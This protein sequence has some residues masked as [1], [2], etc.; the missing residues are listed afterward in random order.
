MGEPTLK[1]A[2][3][4]CGG[5]G[6]ADFKGMEAVC[7]ECCGEGFVYAQSGTTRRQM[8]IAHLNSVFVW[9]NNDTL[10]PRK[11]AQQI[12]RGDLDI[13]PLSWLRTDDIISR[14]KPVTIDHAAELT[15][16]MRHRVMLA[17]ARTK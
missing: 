13:R 14:L 6:K 4:L 1:R 15:D 12:G 3:Y 7:M 10:Y 5:L 9:C 2:C 8:L 11:L 17:N 16:E